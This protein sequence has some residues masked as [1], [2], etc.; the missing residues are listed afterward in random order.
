MKKSGTGNRNPRAPTDIDRLVGENVRRL[1]IVRNLTL[2]QMAADL[3]ISHQQLQKYETGA[4]RLS[5][6]TLCAVADVLGVAIEVLFR[7][8][9]AEPRK[10]ASA[11]EAAMAELRLEGTYWLG[12]A[13]SEQKLRQMIQVLKALSSET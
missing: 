4:N 13:G 12:R 3:S 6:G 11:K 1:R 8:E 5:A 2:A 9:G 7:S 10:P